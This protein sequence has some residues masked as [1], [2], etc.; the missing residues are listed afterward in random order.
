[1]QSLVSTGA[2]RR[3]PGVGGDVARSARRRRNLTGWLFISPIVV[4]VVAFQFFPIFVSMAASLT[5]WDGISP[6]E[7]V[8]LSNFTDIFTDDPLF[9]N[10]LWNTT[11]FTLASIPLTVGIGF[12]L[13]V[14]CA[15]RVRG[16]SFFRT[17]FFAPYVT[18]VVAIG[19]VWFW[20]F[21]P[22][23]GV[24]NGLL[25]QVGIHGPEW[26]SS[27]TW[28]MP[29]VIV[30]SVWQGV[31]YPMIIL[32]AG[33]QGIPE[34][35]YESAKI[36]GAGPLAR[37]RYVTLPLLTPHFLFLLI[38]QFISS[39]QVFGLIYVMT[40]GGPGHSTSVYIYNLYENAFA[41]GKMGYAC[42]LAWILFAVIASVTYAQWKL[43]SR[44][45]FY[46]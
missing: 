21:H 14:L 40:K 37:I 46:A 35:L 44:W 18:N 9:Y 33:L 22:S 42:A 28:A 15:Q 38:T 4:G 17:A 27:S 20:F 43:Q 24:V 16:V 3:T 36:D 26:L 34:M 25:Q 19:F 29:A 2:A 30:V 11:Y 41:Y 10:T 45:V 7:F 13:A 1:M 5:K 8:G 12:F 6:P 39:F 31:G 23:D 32:L